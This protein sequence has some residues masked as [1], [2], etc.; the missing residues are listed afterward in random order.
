MVGDE[1]F[2]VEIRH[3]WPQIFLV[4]ANRFFAAR[5][6]LRL[7]CHEKILLATDEHR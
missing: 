6:L 1:R 5:R 2:F 7:R 3:R 4:L